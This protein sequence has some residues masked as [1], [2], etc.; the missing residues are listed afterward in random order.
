MSL[1][2]GGLLESCLVFLKGKGSLS[3]SPDQASLVRTLQ[4]LQHFLGPYS[5]MGTKVRLLGREEGALT[6]KFLSEAGGGA[7]GPQVSLLCEQQRPLDSNNY[8]LRLF[9]VMKP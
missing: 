4:Q 8:R 7:S 2:P 9:L 6:V 1:V 5:L 3:L